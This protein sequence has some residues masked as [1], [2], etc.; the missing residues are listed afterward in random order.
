MAD[1]EIIQGLPGSN[2][3]KV[4]ECSL[5]EIVGLVESTKWS[6]RLAAKEVETLCRYLRVCDAERGATI[7]REGAREPYLCLIVEGRARIVKEAAGRASRPI[8]FA[9]A[10][11]VVGEM[12]LIDGEPRSASVIAEEASVLVVLTGEAFERLS[13]EAPRLAIKILVKISRLL[14]QR[15]RQTSGVLAGYMDE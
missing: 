13:S 2:G 14:S 8:A 4:R 3:L 7:V 10:G 11:R 9:E 15:L 5:V 6:D 12:S 1:A